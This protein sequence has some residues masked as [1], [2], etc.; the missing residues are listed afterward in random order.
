[1]ASHRFKNLRINLKKRMNKTALIIIIS[2]IIMLK[3]ERTNAFPFLRQKQRPLTYYE[4]VRDFVS[5]F[6]ESMYSS[7]YN[8][9]LLDFKIN[10]FTVL[11][12]VL[13][14]IIYELLKGRHRYAN[15]ALTHGL[16]VSQNNS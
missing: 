2:L 7:A 11:V 9:V 4:I 6:I 8:T 3:I 10:V 13:I 15:K 1:M 16:T 12:V 5:S 14:I